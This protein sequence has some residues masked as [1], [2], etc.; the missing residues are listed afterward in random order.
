MNC[1]H[2]GEKGVNCPVRISV[3]NLVEFVMRSGDLDNRFS[4]INRV[5]EGTRSHQKLQKAAGETYNSEVYLSLDLEY[6]GHSITL[7]GRADG[8]IIEDGR[9]TI[10]E[11]KTTARSLECIDENYNP[12]HWAQAKCYAYIYAK[13]NNL[14]TIGVQLTYFRI[15]TEEKKN[16]VRHFNINELEEFFHGLIGEYAVWLSLEKTWESKRDE[17]IEKLKFPY[18]I[19]RKGQ[20]ELAVAVYRT[21][22]EGKKLFA[23]APTGIGKT[24]STLFPSVKAVGEGHAS[25][26]F[27]LTARTTTRQAAEEAFSVMRESNLMFR[28]IT[29]TAKDK[30][31]FKK[32]AACSPEQCEYARGHFDRVN[33]AI[34]DIL[35]NEDNFSRKVVEEYSEKHRVCPFEYSLD[36]A[37]HADCIICDYN[38][39][40]DPRVYLKRFFLNT[41]GDYAFLIDEAH[42]LVDRSRE[43][44]S[45]E[46][47][48]SSFLKLK[49]VMKTKDTGIY[50]ALSKI[51]TFMIGLRK[52]CQDEGFIVKEDEIKELYKKLKSLIKESED[53]LSKHHGSEEHEQLLELYF[54][55]L[56]FIRI[57]ELF[58]EH[59][60]NF[61]EIVNSE[62]RVRLFCLDPSYLLREAFKRAKTAVL[63]SATLSPLGY[64][65]DILGGSV[66]DYMIKLP[67]PFDSKNLYLLIV[68]NVSTRYKKRESSYDRIAGIIESS[69]SQKNGN[70]MVYFPSYRYMDEVYSRFTGR[71]PGLDTIVQ[72]GT[73]SEEERDAFLDLFQPGKSIGLVGFGV[74]GGVFSEG[75]DLKGDRLIG[76]IIVGVGL[77]QVNPEQDI[78]MK[79]YEKKNSMGFEYA[80]MYPGM[81][82]VLQAAGRV[83]R[84]ESDTG[85][86]ILIDERYSQQDYKGLF[87]D[88]WSHNIKVRKSSE[89]EDSLK[90]F[91]KQ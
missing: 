64:F 89:L 78:I 40:F 9:V 65:R 31:C 59:Y 84:S 82:K 87:P 62:V 61:I 17:S 14:E 50:K 13:Q 36:L 74:L 10:D 1:P 52:E 80:Y 76:V 2:S 41:N 24:I 77:P 86:V 46:L 79:Y 11:I 22:K 37:L 42:N 88:Y 72:K 27:Y 75:I 33:N 66:D 18:S 48:K 73:M 28:T 71:C 55:S 4:G 7:E 16:M 21:I 47:R 12:L 49:K 32:G 91:W 6:E 90:K 19:Y 23:Q 63:F 58:D 30:I 43:M 83:I 70:Y 67:S 51:N 69:V 68:D 44:F 53:W 20:R 35:K 57:S 38:Y 45:A 3:R 54:D 5:L 15:D 39:V 60:V 34:F 81:N 56:A 25:K 8:I 29:L 26:I 85:V